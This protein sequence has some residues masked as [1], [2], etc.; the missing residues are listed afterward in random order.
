MVQ[1]TFIVKH[2]QE[3]NNWFV[4][5]AKDQV[6]GRMASRIAMVLQ[7]KHK[8]I[9]TPNVD[10]GDFVIV[11]NAEK[12]K[13][14]G[15]KADSKVYTHYSGFVG[16]LKEIPFSRMVTNHPDRIIKLAVQRMMPRGPLGRRMLSKLKI[17]AGA[18]HQHQAQQPKPLEFK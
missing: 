10:T 14:T 11:I 7:G 13:V 3:V 15:G 12:V 1:K 18:E 6:L 4:V 17:Y 2:G 5:D 16:G 8:P 9:Y